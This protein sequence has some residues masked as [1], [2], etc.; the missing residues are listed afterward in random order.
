MATAAGDDGVGVAG[1]DVMRRKTVLRRDE[2]EPARASLRRQVAS[3]H[4]EVAA[5][6]SQLNGIAV[7]G[8]RINALVL[9]QSLDDREVA[10]TSSQSDG[11]L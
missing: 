5:H 10:F 7:V 2:T 4:Q 3:G 1:V 6:S 8:R 9:Q 11:V